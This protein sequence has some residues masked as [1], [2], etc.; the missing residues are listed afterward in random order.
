MP[1][2]LVHLKLN[3]AADIVYLVYDEFDAKDVQRN[4]DGSLSV[5]VD[6]PD[7][8]WLYGFL[9]SCGAAAQVIEP[10]RVKDKLLAQIETIK[11]SYS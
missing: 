9:L 6:L 11:Q 4:E 2:T 8:Y 3:F 10:Q 1:N 7:D 5:I